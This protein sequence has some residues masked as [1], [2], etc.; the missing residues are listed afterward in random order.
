MD[1]IRT[2]NE[3]GVAVSKLRS[4]GVIFV[5]K[6]NMHELGMGDTGLNPYHG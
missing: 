2:V 1:E 4:C 3:D 6:T 5:G